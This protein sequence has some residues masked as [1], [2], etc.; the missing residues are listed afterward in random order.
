MVA[1]PFATA[2]CFDDTY[3]FDDTDEQL[4][5]AETRAPHEGKSFCASRNIIVP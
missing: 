5:V 2:Q 4:E 3:E 1:M